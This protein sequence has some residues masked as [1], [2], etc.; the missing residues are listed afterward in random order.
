MPL[1]LMCL[2][3]VVVVEGPRC[4]LGTLALRGGMTGH[5]EKREMFRVSVVSLIRK[6]CEVMIAVKMLSIFPER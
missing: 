4:C 6:I 5:G 2:V 1:V 3:E